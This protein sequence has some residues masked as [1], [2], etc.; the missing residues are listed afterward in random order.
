MR[1][2]D[3]HEMQS[4]LAPFDYDDVYGYSWGRNIIGDGRAAVNASF[5]R[6]FAAQAT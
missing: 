3:V 5:D 1:T 4:R 2:S 6:F